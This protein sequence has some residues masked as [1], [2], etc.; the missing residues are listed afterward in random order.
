M[1]AARRERWIVSLVV[2]LAAGV[3]A[4]ER[5]AGG[6]NAAVAAR[7][8]V[9]T[10][11]A[12]P[13][14]LTRDYFSANGL[15]NRGLYEL[16]AAEYRKFL[17]A[18]PQHP[19]AAV[20]RYG[21]AVALYRE[22]KLAEA[23]T[24]LKQLAEAPA[25]AAF[26]FAPE[27]AALRAQCE[28][29]AGD[30]AAAGATCG[31]FLAQHADHALAPDVAA[32]EVEALYHGSQH[33]VAARQTRVFLNRWPDAPQRERVLLLGGAA[34]ATQKEWAAA[35]ELLAQLLEAF[36]QTTARDQAAW[37]LAQSC[38]ARALDDEAERW[39]RAVLEVKDSPHVPDALLG[40]AAT[41][42]RQGKR[43]A[44][45]AL[46]DRLLADFASSALGPQ[47]LLLR[48]RLLFEEQ[49]YAAA[50]ATFEKLAAAGAEPGDAGAYW[51]AK[52]ALRLERYDDA[53]TQLGRAIE[54]Y[55]KSALR[56]EMLYDRAVALVQ[57]GN[58]DAAAVAALAQFLREQPQHAL[59]ADAL[60]TL[61][62]VEHRAKEYDKSAAHCKAFTEKHSAHA[63]RPAVA[64]LA[65]ENEFL[66]GRYAAAADRYRA[67]LEA[68]KDDPQARR[69]QF[70]LGMAYY[71][72]ERLEDAREPLAEA[73]RHAG[74]DALLRAS[75]LALGE[76]AFARSEWKGAEEWLARY[77]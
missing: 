62:V 9:A 28:L 47:A 40:L 66:A 11:P 5:D 42:H 25:G 74:E 35:G 77:L 58:D 44:A 53:A 24:E 26:P 27:V 37:L 45:G 8:P 63:A 4:Q 48:G 54:A 31:R 20:A 29:A 49:D 22:G 61:A 52:C 13:N 1:H 56:P 41:L 7:K 33:G 75:L 69:A 76:I 19:K 73:A 71:R 32:L 6:D 3:P 18:A 12:E 14:A 16:A 2:L 15:L 57:Q 30:Y 46:L 17:A 64:F 51:R 34:L 67:F 59:A 23:L 55:P 21:L 72:L 65:A 68:Y 60:H 50:A 36:P 43:E 10:Q 39:F 38:V 70:R